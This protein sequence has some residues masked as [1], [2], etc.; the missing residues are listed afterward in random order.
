MTQ[1]NLA[2][3]YIRKIKVVEKNRKYYIW[4]FLNEYNQWVNL[5]ST[6]E[7]D[8]EREYFNYIF[9]RSNRSNSEFFYR[10]PFLNQNL[11]SLDFNTFIQ[12]NLNTGVTRK[13]KRI[14]T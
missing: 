14:L 8:L 3:G 7:Q 11:Y 4:Q 1:K 2:T 10:L 12:T 13:I 5:N 6:L 9:D